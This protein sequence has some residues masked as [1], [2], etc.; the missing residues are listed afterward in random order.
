MYVTLEPCLMCAGAAFWAKLSRLVFA[1]NDSNRGYTTCPF[2]P[3]HS[4]TQ[5]DAGILQLESEQM[6]KRFFQNLR[7]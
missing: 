5:Q 4:R 6:L 2:N 1:A 3:L 7:K